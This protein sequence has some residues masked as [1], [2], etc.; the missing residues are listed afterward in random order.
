MAPDQPSHDP[1]EVLGVAPGASAAEVTSAYRRLVRDLHPDSRAASGPP[2]TARLGQ[3]MA[4]YEVLR[5]P[6]RRAS[7]DRRR[8]LRGSAAV[9]GVQIRVR[10]VEEEPPAPAAPT[11]WLRAGPTRF[12]P[13]ASPRPRPTSRAERASPEDLL[14]DLEA[15]FLRWW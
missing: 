8:Q 7:Y 4:A 5:D 12:H 1:Y 2:D 14:D 13:Q 3:V 9:P 6:A 15:F 10:H 11:A